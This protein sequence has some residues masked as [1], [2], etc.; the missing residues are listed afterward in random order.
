MATVTFT[1]EEIEGDTPTDDVLLSADASVF[2]AAADGDVWGGTLVQIPGVV[3]FLVVSAAPATEALTVEEIV[4]GAAANKFL[5]VQKA[6]IPGD[7]T[8]GTA[9]EA[10]V[11]QGTAGPVYIIPVTPAE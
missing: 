1:V 6:L 5:H 2:G 8:P 7:T 10:T 11:L 3:S 9:L 4:G